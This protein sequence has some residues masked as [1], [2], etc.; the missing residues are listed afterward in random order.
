MFI[1]QAILLMCLIGQVWM[2]WGKD[3]NLVWFYGSCAVVL[4]IF[5]ILDMIRGKSQNKKL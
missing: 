3:T 1:I 2:H 5:M 4:T